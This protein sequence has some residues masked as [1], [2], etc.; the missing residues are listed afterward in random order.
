MK[1]SILFFLLVPAVLHA[2]TLEVKRMEMKG[3]NIIV[4]YSLLDTVPGRTYSINMYASRD[5]YI[6][7]LTQLIGDHG[8]QVKPGNERTITWNAKQELGEAY[9]GAVSVELR[10]KAYVAFILFDNFETIK[11]GK[12]KEVTWRG[13]TRQN[14]LNFELYN[15][16][17]E[18]VAVIPNVPNA[19]HTSLLVPGDVKPGK[20]YT[21]K[22]VDSKNKDQVVYTETFTVKRRVPIAVMIAGAAAIGGGVALLGGGDES[23]PSTPSA[24]GNPPG[25]P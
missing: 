15:R 8:L 20:G 18:K 25:T 19:G 3:G 5:N 6:N 16:K 1:Y 2:Q 14:I 21:F 10:A 4:H 9:Q 24:I 11:K 12:H 7:P 17:G 23:G 22:I 13:G